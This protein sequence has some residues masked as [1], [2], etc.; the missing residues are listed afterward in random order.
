MR[1]GSARD[2]GGMQASCNVLHMHADVPT[3]LPNKLK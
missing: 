1:M 3:Q 2:G